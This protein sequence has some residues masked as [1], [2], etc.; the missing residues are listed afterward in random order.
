MVVYHAIIESEKQFTGY[1]L[2]QACI[3]RAK[4]AGDSNPKLQVV[5]IKVAAHYDEDGQ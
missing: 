1:I 5:T 3:F 4:V 2:K